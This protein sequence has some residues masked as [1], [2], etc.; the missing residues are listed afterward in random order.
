VLLAEDNAVNR[1]VATRTL[2]KR[3]H[4]VR[5][6]ENGREAVRA[7]EIGSFD[8]V[9]MDVQMP[10]M[11]GLEATA[12]IRRKEQRAFSRVTIIALT[13][14]A[15]KGDRERCLAAGMDDY[16]TK[17]FKTKDLIL[18]VE[19]GRGEFETA[20]DPGVQVLNHASLLERVEGD[21][22]L[23]GEL[24]K[25]FFEETPP[26]LSAIRSAFQE[27]NVT[28]I[29]KAAHR[30]RGTLTTIGAE[31]ASAPALKLELS[32]RN[33]PPEPDDAA[34]AELERELLQLEPE[35]LKLAVG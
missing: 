6:V 28:A 26:L 23:V 11:D 13:A 27:G 17:P 31:R 32:S 30:L 20:E 29:G 22:I 2:E 10:V 1:T 15:M 24:V 33:D 3:G 4:F 5:A 16:L 18:A 34:L 9:L 35:L 7:F 14:H 25:V 21:Q 8:V 12:L 19:T